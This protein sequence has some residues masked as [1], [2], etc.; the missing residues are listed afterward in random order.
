MKKTLSILAVL[1]IVSVA[2]MQTANAFSWS[3]L[4]PFNWGRCNRCEQ[5]VEKCPCST[6]Y[7]APCN[8]CEKKTPCTDPCT[9]Q[10]KQQSVPCDACD[11]LQQDM[12]KR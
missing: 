1:G 10:I 11:K 7:A 3:N 12:Q 4:N 8:P 2:G 9:N 5:K 6:G